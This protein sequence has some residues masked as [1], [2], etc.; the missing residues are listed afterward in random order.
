ML[1]SG[2]S[3]V[4]RGKVNPKQ[5]CDLVRGSGN[6]QRMESVWSDKPS[7]LISV[8]L[9]EPSDAPISRPH[10]AYT[11]LR[12]LLEGTNVHEADL[13]HVRLT[14][15]QS[16]KLLCVYR[17]QHDSIGKLFHNAGLPPNKMTPVLQCWRGSSMSHSVHRKE[18]NAHEL[19]MWSRTGYLDGGRIS[20]CSVRSNVVRTTAGNRRR[21]ERDVT[22]DKERNDA[23][24][25]LLRP[26]EFNL[27]RSLLINANRLW[28]NSR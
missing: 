16:W 13:T 17:G 12:S 7:T 11:R 3:D 1:T 18:R 25:K 15:N 26:H 2:R 28:E 20:G 22:I 4:L 19:D 9:S 5:A 27:R 24:R 6:K 8:T 23:Q 14:T 10:E 21:N